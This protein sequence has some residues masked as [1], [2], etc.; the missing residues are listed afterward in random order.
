MQPF[1]HL[2]GIDAVVDIAVFEE[3]VAELIHDLVELLAHF[4]FDFCIEFTVGEHACFPGE[5]LIGEVVAF[6]VFLVLFLQAIDYFLERFL[7]AFDHFVHHLIGGAAM[8]AKV[9][10]EIAGAVGLHGIFGLEVLLTQGDGRNG[11]FAFCF[12]AIIEVEVHLFRDCGGNVVGVD[13]F[14]RIAGMGFCADDIEAR[15]ELAHGSDIDVA[16][17]VAFKAGCAIVGVDHGEI[18]KAFFLLEFDELF[19][20]GEHA[21]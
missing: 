4:G 15:H 20:D 5:F 7:C 12:V 21:F 9:E 14:E 17:V 11:D 3:L 8:R 16:G 19:N 1:N 6:A 18:F 10:I 13:S 2:E